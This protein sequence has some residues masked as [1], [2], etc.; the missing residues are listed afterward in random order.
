MAAFLSVLEASGFST[1][2]REV[3]E[4]SAKDALP[5]TFGASR[6]RAGLLPSWSG[7]RPLTPRSKLQFPP[8]RALALVALG[9]AGCG[10]NNNSTNITSIA[11]SPTAI[12][13]GLNLQTD[14]TATV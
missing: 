10:G 14:F 6:E 3:L 1:A 9:F 11:I 13:V 4:G 12:T 5:Q 8:V 2:A 7:R